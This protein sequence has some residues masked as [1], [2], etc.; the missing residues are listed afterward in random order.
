MCY[1][2][3]IMVR[4]INDYN[5]GLIT[6]GIYSWMKLQEKVTYMVDYNNPKIT[7]CVY[8][9]WHGNQ[10]CVHGLPDKNNVN[11]LI[12]TSKDGQIVSDICHRMGFQTCRG[13]SMRRGAVSG[14]LKL[15]NKLKN[16]ENVAIMVDGPRGPLHSVKPGAIAIA[17][18]A[19][20]P[21]VPMNWY[22]K[23]F[24]FVKFNTWDK[25]TCPF[26]PARVLNTFGEPIY[27]EGKTDEEAA[28]E[29]KT[30]LLKLDELSPERFEKAKKMKL[31]EKR[32]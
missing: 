21:I 1:N 31:W 15:I 29:I 24:T 16:G 32:Q 9:M 20:V 13:S 12:S 25:M 8:V 18:E 10:F 30:A 23:D 19:K 6:D 14:T 26:G 22:S 4:L 28:E 27:V 11:I 3:F 17:R 2:S 7:P 5:L